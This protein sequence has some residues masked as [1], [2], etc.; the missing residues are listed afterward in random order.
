MLRMLL[1]AVV[2]TSFPVQAAA[3]SIEGVW[4]AVEVELRGGPNPGIRPV[5]P[6]LLLF[7]DRHFAWVLDSNTEP[8]RPVADATDAQI[9]ALLQGVAAN[10]GTYEIEG[11]TIRYFRTVA[12]DP[13]AVQPEAQPFERRFRITGDRLETTGTNANG[14]TTINRY[15]RVEGGA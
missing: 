11:A 9:V 15:R 5:Q 14:V 1:M 10:A 7:T 2:L 13:A 3:Q 6:G 12:I 4:Q 8:R